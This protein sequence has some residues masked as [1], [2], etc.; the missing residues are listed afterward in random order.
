MDKGFTPK[1]LQVLHLMLLLIPKEK[2]HSTLYS[3]VKLW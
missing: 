1:I 2:G 3:S